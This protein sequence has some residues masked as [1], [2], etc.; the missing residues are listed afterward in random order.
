M[1]QQRLDAVHHLDDVRARLPLDVDDHRGR[2]VHPRGLLDV[3]HAVDDV[4]DI[5]ERDRRAVA[6][7][8]DERLVIRA[9]Q[10][11]IV[12]AD[13]ISLLRAVE[14]SLGLNS[15]LA[16]ASAVRTSSRLIP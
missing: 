14:V 11:L 7:G 9:G 15:G 16:A 8:D 13:L 2:L 10:K 5:G 6:V 1:R 4:R 3:L 12:R